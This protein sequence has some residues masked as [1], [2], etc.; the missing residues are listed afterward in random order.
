M[1]LALVNPPQARLI[2]P[3]FYPPIGLC[4]LAAAVKAWRPHVN[5]VLENLAGATPDEAV[6]RLKGYDVVGYSV[7]TPYY[8]DTVAL[9]KRVAKHVK[10]QIIGGAHVTVTRERDTVF[11]SIFVGEAEHALCEY[12][13]DF[14]SGYVENLYAQQPNVL[15]EL[16]FPENPIGGQLNHGGA[17][18]TAVVVTSRGCTHKCVFCPARTMYK[19][20]R[21]RSVQNIAEELQALKECGIAEIRFMDDAFSMQRK[22]TFD[23]CE[24]LG[25]MG[26]RWGAMV[27]V[28]QVDPKLL[29]AMRAGGCREL[30]YG[31]ESFDQ[32]VLDAIEKRTTVAQNVAAMR[33]T[34]EA[35]ILVHALLMIS[36]PGEVYGETPWL[37]IG[38]LES[39]KSNYHKFNFSVLIPHVGTPIYMNP[40]GYGVKIVCHDF[41]LYSRHQHEKTSAGVALRPVWSPLRIYGMTEAE[42]YDNIR[43]FRE[44][45]YSLPQRKKDWARG[46]EFDDG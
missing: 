36:T 8:K 38:A 29:K 3:S 45:A 34:R 31:F 23:L 6:Q 37:N 1:R 17:Q 32:R 25:S 30:A 14:Q 5:V 16:P 33:W 35:G 2:D 4:Y 9:A 24:V 41:G 15:D 20:V 19:R 7:A 44:Y 26:F 18:Q 10:H 27:R 39:M 40:G 28:D 21:F 11:E 42:Q 13:D 43:M 12:I 46:G 22:R